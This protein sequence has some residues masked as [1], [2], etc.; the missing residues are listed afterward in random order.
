MEDGQ[1]CQRITEL[2]F[3]DSIPLI[4]G[5]LLTSPT[6]ANARRQCVPLTMSFLSLCADSSHPPGLPN[7]QTTSPGTIQT[8]GPHFHD[9]QHSQVTTQH[10]RHVLSDMT[11]YNCNTSNATTQPFAQI[12]SDIHH[13]GDSTMDYSAC[14]LA[15]E[16]DQ[17]YA[18]GNTKTDD[19][20]N[21]HG[22]NIGNSSNNTGNTSTPPSNLLSTP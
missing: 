3:G 13:N 7:H 9:E 15:D 17:E 11:T 2:Q 18:D 10:Q 8:T 20:Y 21:T 22:N 6:T 19:N 5:S 16:S 1:E 4:S 12:Q 14:L